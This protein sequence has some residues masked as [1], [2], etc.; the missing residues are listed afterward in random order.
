MIY[1]E[2]GDCAEVTHKAVRIVD[3][4]GHLVE[5]PL[6]VSQLAA[7][8]VEL[9][10]YRHYMQ[11]EIFEQPAAVAA[12][13]EAVANAT[14]VVPHVFGANAAEVFAQTQSA[15][16]LACGTSYHAG[17]VA[18]YWIE[19]LAGIPCNVEI[20]SEYRYRDSVPNEHALVVVI[21]Q[22]GET[23]DTIAALHHARALGQHNALAICPSPPSS[24]AP[25]CASSPAP[26]RR[27]AS[28]PPRPSPRSSR[29]SL[30]SPWCSRNRKKD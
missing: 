27:S 7:D 20:A 29:R 24:A 30:R 15:L 11:K 25:T 14:S 12:T 1:L 28:P 5:R 10:T 8:A 6:H 9:G 22:S 4:R 23:A 2:E 26:V 13:L 16:I 17:V 21:S 18:R 3:A 19:G